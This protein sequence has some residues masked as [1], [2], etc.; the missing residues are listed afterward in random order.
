MCTE[1]NV[2]GKASTN[3]HATE[4]ISLMKEILHDLYCN[5][6]VIAQDFLFG[7]D[8]WLEAMEDYHGARFLLSDTKLW[9]SLYEQWSRIHRTAKFCGKKLWWFPYV[10]SRE[11]DERG[12]VHSRNVPRNDVTFQW[13][14]IVMTTLLEE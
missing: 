10:S 4:I 13:I 5:N 12:A 11:Q 2:R 8:T 9:N 14:M 6:P 3:I 7:A 1:T